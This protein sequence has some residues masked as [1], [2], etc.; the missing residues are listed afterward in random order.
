MFNRNTI[1]PI[2]AVIV[3]LAA[4]L[5]NGCNSEAPTPSENL[6]ATL[7]DT[8]LEHA[9]K[10]QDPSYV[11]P[12]HPQIVRGEPGNCPICG[13]DLV[14]KSVTADDGGQPEISIS[15]RIVQSM[16]VRTAPVERGTLW[17]RIRTVGRVDYDET[18]RAHVHP[19]ANG[20]MER[21]KIRAEGDQV[22]QGQV[23][24]H[25]YAPDILSAQVDFLIALKQYARQPSRGKVDKARN[26]LRLLDVPDHIIRQI[27]VQGETRNTVPVLAP[28][29][30]VVTRMGI[31]DGMYVTP[32]SKL[33]T[34]ADLSRVWVLVDVFEHQL[35]WL[36]QGLEAEIRIPAR[37]GQRW[38]G[39][40]DY[41]YPEL[42]P[43]TRTLKIRLSFPNPDGRLRP[44]MFAEVVIQGGEKS[45][46]LSV[47]RAALIVTGERKS[48][49][50][51]LG[52]GRFQ[53]VDVETGMRSDGRVEILS[54]L[55]EAD[56][57]VVSGQFLIDS[58]SNLQASFLRMSATPATSAHAHH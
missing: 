6:E 21:L 45:D 23:L 47:P 28:I 55:G 51:A 57:I 48:V 16:G 14:A 3:L 43:H 22:K 35:E 13:M 9:I 37:P 39:K 40:V 19:R 4:L 52:D 27:E 32:G 7:D 34:I 44:N 15:G 11:C 31:R 20:W 18:R 2:S 33:V 36:E 58:E 29:D 17:K 25:L 30:G 24:G 26:L 1:D 38:Q 56:E 10:H 8:A 50:K 49:V 12:M 42:D 54:G 41:I 53:P 5:L 46:A